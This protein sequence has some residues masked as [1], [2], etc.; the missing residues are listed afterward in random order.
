MIEGSLTV[1]ETIHP[2]LHEKVLQALK[3][4]HNIFSNDELDKWINSVSI[5]VDRMVIKDL[6]LENNIIGIPREPTKYKSKNNFN[7]IEVEFEYQKPG[8]L[9]NV[10][11]KNFVIH[12]MFYQV[13]H[14][15]IDDT[16]FI[17]PVS[18]EKLEKELIKEQFYS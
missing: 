11:S 9:K 18:S 10:S 1:F 14:T 5:S 8:K 13:L 15:W 4:R 3:K 6:L 7:I 12:P 17:I 16:N 2:E